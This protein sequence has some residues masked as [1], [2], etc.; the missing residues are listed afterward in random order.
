MNLNAT[1]V[2]EKQEL[3]ELL[4]HKGRMHLLS[5]LTDY[6]LEKKTV[7]AETDIAEDFI[8]YEE[9]LGGAP[10]WS[11]FEIMAQ[12]I[13]A[14]TGIICR[15]NNVPPMAGCILSISDFSMDGKA[16]PLGSKIS[17]TSE[18]EFFDA[19]SGIYRYKSVAFCSDRPGAQCAKATLTVMQMDNIEDLLKK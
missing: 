13:S 3:L 12:S 14:L 16:F 18:E 15:R 9:D 6:D 4:P 5:R 10:D 1:N 8:F 19:E 11:V 2:I 17:V 7:A